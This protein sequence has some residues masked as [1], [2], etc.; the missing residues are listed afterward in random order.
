MR[1]AAKQDKVIWILTE[2]FYPEET[3]SGYYI[4][5]IAEAIAQRY[6][7]RVL[8]VQPTY[9]SRGNK[10]PTDEVFNNVRIHRCM[11]TTLNKDILPLLSILR[12]AEK[13]FS[14][15]WACRNAAI[16]LCCA[17]FWQSQG[18]FDYGNVCV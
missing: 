14:E 15:V 3:G 18:A 10:A 17:V 16:T 13:Y 7:V 2:L 6:C 1:V 5:P 12:S 11:A 4:T 8:T 9:A